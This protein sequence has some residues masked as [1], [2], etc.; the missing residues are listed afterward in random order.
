MPETDYARSQQKGVQSAAE[1]TAVERGVPASRSGVREAGQPD[2]WQRRP[3][4]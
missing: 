1:E 4:P 3:G 2:V